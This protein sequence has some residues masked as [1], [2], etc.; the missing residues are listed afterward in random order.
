MGLQFKNKKNVRKTMTIFNQIMNLPFKVV[1]KWG[2][3][4]LLDLSLLRVKQHQCQALLSKQALIL[5]NDI[6]INIIFTITLY[7]NI[8]NTIKQK[9]TKPQIFTAW[10]N[11]S[12]GML[13]LIDWLKKFLS[14]CAA[15]IVKHADPQ[16]NSITRGVK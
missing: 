12:T 9:L 1:K 6:F 15:C 2:W 4:L 13:I 16:M 7:Y 3:L 14:N 11:R 8:T 10:L 5:H